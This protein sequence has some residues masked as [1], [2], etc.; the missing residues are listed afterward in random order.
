[1]QAYKSHF[2]NSN[3]VEL[4]ADSRN[5]VAKSIV[6]DT[7]VNINEPV[8]AKIYQDKLFEMENAWKHMRNDADV[9]YLLVWCA[10]LNPWKFGTQELYYWIESLINK[11]EKNNEIITTAAVKEM[12]CLTLTT[13][14]YNI[15]QD[16]NFKM[17]KELQLCNQLANL[18]IENRVQDTIKLLIDNEHLFHIA[19]ART[20]ALS[21]LLY[22]WYQDHSTESEKIAKE[23]IWVHSIL[24]PNHIH[25][26]I[27]PHYKF[28]LGQI[29]N[30]VMKELK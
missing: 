5:I 15:E 8:N 12:L 18:I 3:F 24:D 23:W 11:L 2:I 1:M 26:T 7:L 29:N 10:T 13:G 25:Y 28:V 19:S 20:Y 14:Y 17:T 9:I 6:I 30:R 4:D 16:K 21:E 27:R 22:Q